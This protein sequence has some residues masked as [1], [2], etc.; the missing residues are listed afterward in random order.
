MRTYQHNLSYL[1]ARMKSL[2][3]ILEILSIIIAFSEI[4]TVVVIAYC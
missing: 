4:D 3:Q 1:I 2:K